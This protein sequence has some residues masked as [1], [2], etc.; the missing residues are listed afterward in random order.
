METPIFSLYVHCDCKRKQCKK[1]VTPSERVVHLRLKRNSDRR[2]AAA[3]AK[4]KGEAQPPPDLQRLPDNADEADSADLTFS[5]SIPDFTGGGFAVEQAAAP[6]TPNSSREVEMLADIAAVQS[7]PAK[8]LEAIAQWRLLVLDEARKRRDCHC[9]DDPR[10]TARDVLKVLRNRQ[11]EGRDYSFCTSCGATGASTAAEAEDTAATWC[12]CGAS[13]IN[14]FYVPIAAYVRVLFADPQFVAMIAYGNR[15]RTDGVISDVQ[16]GEQW[17]AWATEGYFANRLNLALALVPDKLD[18]DIKFNKDHGYNCSYL[19]VLNLPP[20]ARHKPGNVIVPAIIPGSETKMMANAIMELLVAELNDIGTHGLHVPVAGRDGEHHVRVRLL[21]CAGDLPALT[22]L[23]GMCGHRGNLPCPFCRLKVKRVR[24]EE[25]EKT[26]F[27]DGKGT[28][29]IL[30]TDATNRQD[31]QNVLSGTATT[32]QTGVGF[33]QLQNLAGFDT[34]AGRGIDILHQC[35]L[36]L[37]N[38]L[39]NAALDSSRD[40]NAAELK[41]R[42]ST[43]KKRLKILNAQLAYDEQ[44]HMKHVE[45]AGTKHVSFMGVEA[46]RAHMIFCRPL[47]HDMVSPN[48]MKLLALYH[49]ILS[50]VLA[51]DITNIQ[52]TTLRTLVKK[53]VKLWVT[54]LGPNSTNIALHLL[55]HLP[56]VIVQL[57]PPIAFSCFWAE[58]HHQW[59]KRRTTSG[60]VEKRQQE[61]VAQYTAF[62]TQ[63]HSSTWPVAFSDWQE[64]ASL[65]CDLQTM[66]AATQTR[67]SR[68]A[69]SPA[70]RPTW[71]CRLSHA[72]TG[73][74]QGWAD[75]VDDDGTKFTGHLDQFLSR[76][77]PGAKVRHLQCF[78]RCEVN[79][80]VFVST[81][82]R[83]KRTNMVSTYFSMQGKPAEY[84]GEVQFFVKAEFENAQK[85]QLSLDLAFVKWRVTSLT[86]HCNVDKVSGLPLIHEAYFPE[87]DRVVPCRQLLFRSVTCPSGEDADASPHCFAVD[88]HPFFGFRASLEKESN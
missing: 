10:L 21:F 68:T 9:D 32:T 36:S 84:H 44:L 42:A 15:P 48:V 2:L 69:F 35:A 27:E 88:I 61:A 7:L 51:F 31:V 25:K 65:R 19:A 8:T 11:L 43:F 74:H 38:V 82:Y 57:G 73:Q 58:R 55:T 85:E 17:K 29:Q 20:N 47:F 64:F 22:K 24:V 86:G 16:D 76:Y 67:I 75:A 56:D 5:S 23:F 81:G 78:K 79:G 33:S 13:R 66:T 1:R 26:I 62:F 39:F 12:T 60:R 71:Y 54:T 30:R 40:T 87:D 41:I 4:R 3:R 53:F 6:P 46:L 50:I 49:S 28:A 14:F 77:H 83:H 34:V 72:V 37:C 80:M 18:P 52:I 59:F 45:V 70:E 63:F